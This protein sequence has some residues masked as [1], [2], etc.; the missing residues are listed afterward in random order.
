MAYT[1]KHGDR[2]LDGYTIQRAV[3]C[4][5]FG[6]V[7]Y[8][9]SDGGREVAL[10]YLKS[11]PAIELRGVSHCINLKS[12][13]LVSIF[14]VK[15]NT[16]GEYFVIMEYCS[17]PSLRDL[18][19]AEPDGFGPQ[20]SA[21]FVREIA[22]GLAYLHDQGI[23]H[24]DMKPGNIFFDDGYV[25]I[26]DYGLS[27]FISVSRHSAQTASV[28]TVH[29]MAPEIG[30]GNYSAGVDIYA[31][32]VMLYEMLLGR[33]PFE[34]SSM[35]EILMKHLTAQPELDDLPHPF[36]EVI[37]KSLQ[38]DPKDR[39]QSANEM[40]EA[41]L[42]V[43]EVRQSLAG[44]SVKSLAGAV[45]HGPVAGASSPIPSPNPMP[46]QAQGNYPPPPPQR[47]R[48]H[49]R[50][51]KPVSELISKRVSK[52]QD[53][54]ARKIDKKMA[55]LSGGRLPKN[56]TQAYSA[57]SR[58]SGESPGDFVA[59]QSRRKRMLLCMLASAALAFG[60]AIAFGNAQNAP[61]GIATG[62]MIIAM[63][64]GIGIGRK[65]VRWFAAE[66][67]PRWANALLRIGSCAPLLFFAGIPMLAEHS[68]NDEGLAVIFA[69]LIVVWLGNWNKPFERGYAGELSLGTA[70]WT[71]F[72]GMMAGGIVI[73]IMECNTDEI[74]MPTAAVIAG[75]VSLIIQMSSW[76]IGT[77]RP[78]LTGVDDDEQDQSPSS[79][80]EDSGIL[81]AGLIIG[82]GSD[83]KRPVPVRTSD[84]G[85]I[86]PTV[87]LRRWGITR[88]MWGMM[89]FCS[90]CGAL[91]LSL[92]MGLHDDFNPSQFAPIHISESTSEFG[93]VI[94]SVTSSSHTISFNS[95]NY[96]DVT[97]MIIGLIACVVFSLYA[98]SKTGPLCKEGFWLNT[99]KP[100]MLTIL[101]FGIGALIT[102]I[103]R[104]WHYME[105]QQEASIA[106]IFGLVTTSI[107]WIVIVLF[108]GQKSRP[109]PAFVQPD[110]GASSEPPTYSTPPENDRAV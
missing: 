15:K 76:W 69:M 45:H 36:G 41:L 88:V 55:K 13:Y 110:V 108:T 47:D 66:D 105:E 4:G 89:S 96:D 50:V 16:D 70:I 33:V 63:S 85:T 107:A 30:S 77:S 35:G 34:G 90:A 24:R 28:G 11:N 72:G 59:R 14:D 106:L 19:I 97:G 1:F 83:A 60:A 95:G 109:Q 62:M 44:F 52:R 100:F 84:R 23:V 81:V 56:Q 80:D 32:G 18:M 20:K 73:A 65:A 82:A 86:D 7:Y 94:S 27:K 38:K 22:K 54:I 92:V 26:G 104:N 9:L 46:R 5:G 103:S 6:E 75:S 48:K 25:K 40:I 78:V 51:R 79:T 67:G 71:G 87:H 93:H 29:Y 43:D 2:P 39:Y 68:T 98:A 21:F 64:G 61:Y 10:K 99:F 57:A 3:G 31:L 12:P 37:R 102:G 91:A 17:G 49:R 74:V 42:D 101:T 8:A 58:R 53:R